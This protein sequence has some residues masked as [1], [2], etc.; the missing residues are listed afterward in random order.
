MDPVVHF[1]FPFDDRT[2]IAKF[3]EAA[4]GWKMQM[5]GEDMGDYVVVTTAD[6]D[7]KGEGTFKGAIGGGFFPRKPDWPAQYPSVVIAVQDI[8]ASMRK[9]AQAGGEVFGEPMMIPG[10]GD[11]VAFQDT[12]GNRVSMLQPLPRQ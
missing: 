9:V 12:E 1:E 10:I 7:I 11:Y 2:R 5:L 3:Y 6:E 4:F 8:Q